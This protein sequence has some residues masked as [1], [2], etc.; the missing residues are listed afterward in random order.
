MGKNY[1]LLGPETGNK[2]DFIQ[3]LKTQFSKDTEFYK[4]FPYDDFETPL[5]DALNNGSL[6]ASERFVCVEVPKEY[7]QKQ[8]RPNFFKKDL[9]SILSSYLSHP[10]DCVTLVIC[11]VETAVNKSIEKFF[12]AKDPNFITQTYWEMKDTEKPGW[13]LNFFRKNN[14]KINNEAISQILLLVDNNT[15]EMRTICSQLAGFF[16]LNNKDL[17]TAD[18]IDSYISHT[19]SEDG[20][21]LFSYIAKGQLKQALSCSLFLLNTCTDSMVTVMSNLIWCFRRLHSVNLLLNTG[22]SQWDAF[23][24][25]NVLGKT[26]KISRPNDVTTYKA[27]LTRYGTFECEN[28]ISRLAQSELEL[29]E[30]GTELLSLQFTKLITDIISTY[31]KDQ[32][33]VDFPTL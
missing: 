16:L 14:L 25:A 12:T 2:S 15:L 1:L 6:F 8:T 32:R 26:S 9:E 21:S 22:K 24:E 18:D 10:D 19:R 31:C 5:F 33:K 29:R 13:V 23:Q 27:A 30:G 3:E 4:F 11:T 7:T 20:F 28:I 17:I